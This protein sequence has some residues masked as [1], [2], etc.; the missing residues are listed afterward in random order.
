MPT[1]FHVIRRRSGLRSSR[2]YSIDDIRQPE[3]SNATK[4]QTQPLTPISGNHHSWPLGAI[5]DDSAATIHCLPL[6]R[7][8]ADVRIYRVL[9]MGLHD[10]Y[11][12]NITPLSSGLRVVKNDLTMPSKTPV[13]GAIVYRCSEFPSARIRIADPSQ[14]CQVV[15]S[16]RLFARLPDN[17]RTGWRAI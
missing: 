17:T 4:R 9:V 7:Y 11:C 13:Y 16:I 3:Q 10:D 12:Q 14:H 8:V 15:M 2:L 6:K 1:Y 5:N